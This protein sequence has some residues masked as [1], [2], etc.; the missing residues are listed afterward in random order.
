MYIGVCR[1]Q[2]N[3]IAE[4]QNPVPSYGNAQLTWHTWKHSD[5]APH[6]MLRV[7]FIK[8]QME[9]SLFRWL[10]REPQKGS[11]RYLRGQHVLTQHPDWRG[12]GPSIPPTVCHLAVSSAWG[13][14]RL[15]THACYGLL[16]VYRLTIKYLSRGTDVTRQH[17]L[18]HGFVSIV[19]VGWVVPWSDSTILTYQ[20]AGYYLIGE[21]DYFTRRGKSVH[22]YG[23]TRL[24]I[25]LLPFFS[26]SRTYMLPG[27]SGM[28]RSF[29]LS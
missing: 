2:C 17:R 5:Y 28:L 11:I 24:C 9:S 7:F 1:S 19:L 20:V 26:M 13:T 15:P 25:L 18:S 10:N 29:R 14:S 8:G 16:A 12:V 21:G 23:I 27:W 4:G 22:S 6:G 3:V